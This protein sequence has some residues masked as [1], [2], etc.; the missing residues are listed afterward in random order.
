MPPD[1][2]LPPQ[3]TYLPERQYQMFFFHLLVNLETD[4]S[5]WKW[6]FYRANKTFLEFPGIFAS[7]D[8]LLDLDEEVKTG[9]LEVCAKEASC[10]GVELPANR[11]LSYLDLDT[12]KKVEGGVTMVKALNVH[13]DTNID[14]ENSWEDLD[15]CCPKSGKVTDALVEKIEDHLERVPCDLPQEVNA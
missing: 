10:V 12:L 6:N 13:A 8:P 7:T 11:L 14:S 4:Y 9:S 1:Y 15:T 5:A 3:G 2:L